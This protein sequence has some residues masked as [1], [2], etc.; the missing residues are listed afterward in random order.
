[1]QEP[2]K[3]QPVQELKAAR[4]L[5]GEMDWPAFWSLS[6]SVLVHNWSLPTLSRCHCHAGE[7]FPC[8][9]VFWAGDLGRSMGGRLWSL[10]SHR[11]LS[12]ALG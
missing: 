1:V 2:L 4:A 5:G 9:L 12:T 7:G 11:L 8:A 3:E 10:R 6:I